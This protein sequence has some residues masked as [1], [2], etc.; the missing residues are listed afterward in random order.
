MKRPSG[1]ELRSSPKANQK[2][3]LSIPNRR[4]QQ[5]FRVADEVREVL[6]NKAHRGAKPHGQISRGDAEARRMFRSFKNFGSSD[7]LVLKLKN[8]CFFVSKYFLTRNTRKD[9]L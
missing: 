4:S 6:K 7:K 9:F 2:F 1:A 5:R 3:E 8:R